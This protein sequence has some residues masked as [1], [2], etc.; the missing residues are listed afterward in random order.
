GA[1]RILR[2]VGDR[3]A[4]GLNLRI[5][6]AIALKRGDHASARE[7]HA[8]ALAVSREMG[9]VLGMIIGHSAL[10]DLA[11]AH[12]RFQ[13]AH[14]DYRD[15]LRL[16]RDRGARA[17]LEIVSFVLRR[18]GGLN[19]LAGDPGRAARIFGAEAAGRG[20]EPT[21][22][23]DQFSREPYGGDLAAAR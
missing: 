1:R 20:A 15:A 11:R 19:A 17:L 23:R 2:E 5:C 16:G 18:L 10:G 7:L 8:E 9:N 21:S 3:E 12:G 22:A 6:G 4:L 14:E 13:G